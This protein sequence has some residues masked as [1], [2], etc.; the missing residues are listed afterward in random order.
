MSHTIKMFSQKKNSL[1]QKLFYD[2]FRCNSLKN[3][4]TAIRLFNLA[5]NLT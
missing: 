1:K 5:Q 4:L 3:H 2:Y